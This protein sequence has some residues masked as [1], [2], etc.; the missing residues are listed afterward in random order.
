AVAVRRSPRPPAMSLPS[1]GTP[2]P[3]TPPKQITGAQLLP[4]ILRLTGLAWLVMLVQ[5]IALFARPTPYGDRY[6]EDWSRYFPYVPL[7]NLIGVAL[8]AAPFLLIGII[9]Y[10]RRMP[11]W[12]PWV[13]LAILVASVMLDQLDHEVMRFMGTHLTLGL[14]RTYGK[15]GA[16]GADVGRSL[17]SDRGGPGLPLLLLVASPA[18][19]WWSGSRS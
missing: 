15:I 9:T 14:M 19:L 10:R 11:V 16:W 17:T 13:F 18:L 8:L 6:V 5:A 4:V 7:Y 3:Q 1:R 2:A 12:L